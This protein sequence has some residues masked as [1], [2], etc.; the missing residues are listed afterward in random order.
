MIKHRDNETVVVTGLEKYLGCSVVR[1]NQTSRAPNYP[2]VVYS[3]IT[4]KSANNGTWSVVGTIHYKQVTQTWSFTAI[5]ED[6]ET[7]M[8]LAMKVVDWFDCVGRN[9]LEDAGVH[10]VRTQA[11][12]NRDTY[13]T[14]EYEHRFGVDITLS[15]LDIV[16]TRDTQDTQ[17]T[18]EQAVLQ[19]SSHGV[20]SISLKRMEE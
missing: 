14:I 16:D 13:L 1:Q 5:A 19:T 7:A 2:Y 17:D 20:G 6:E 4:P 9:T 18:I 11:L 8:E 15:M 10:L 3:V 12:A